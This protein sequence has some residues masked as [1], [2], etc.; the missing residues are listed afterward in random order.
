MPFTGLM[1]Y[2]D[3]HNIRYVVITHSRAYTAQGTAALAHIPGKELAKTVMVK[4]DDKLVMAVLP[5]LFH[6]DL[7]ML[8]RATNANIAELASEN[9]FQNC[10][11]EC[12]PGAMPPFGNLYGIDIYAEESL[13]E[14]KEIAF[15]AGSHLELIRPNPQSF[16]SLSGKKFRQRNHFQPKR[17]TSPSP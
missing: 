17:I 12:E 5:A 2:L 9:E 16:A 3:K 10:F 14:D 15:N 1:E 6:V 4:L 7:A 11:P 8:K 13:A